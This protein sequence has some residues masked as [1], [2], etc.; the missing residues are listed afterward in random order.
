MQRWRRAKIPAAGRHS[1]GRKRRHRHQ[2]RAHHLR[3]APACQLRAALRRHGRHAPRTRRRND[4]RQDQL[5]RVR[6]GIV[7]RK[8]RIWSREEPACAGP[9]RRRIERRI[10]R[11]GGAGNGPARARL[12][13]RRLRPSAGLVLRRRRRHANLR[14][15]IAIRAGRVRQFARPCRSVRPYRARCRASSR[16]YRRPRRARRDFR[17]AR[18]SPIISPRSTA[19]SR[20]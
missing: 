10:G 5:R 3:L 11:G 1:R 4:Y 15:S 18:P 6:D 7:E 9:R 20:A 19:R 13:Y 16:R 8:L 14:A 2:R 12:R 17:R